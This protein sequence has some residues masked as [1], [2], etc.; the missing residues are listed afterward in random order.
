MAQ[1]TQQYSGPRAGAEPK[2]NPAVRW[3]TILL[4]LVFLALSGVIGRD[5]WYRYQDNDPQNSWV[6][7]VLDWLGTATVNPVGVTVG[8][9]VAL[10]GLWLIITAF[11]PR[12]RR[13]VRIESASSI[14]TRP[15]DI[16]RKA[17]ASARSELGRSNIAS[18]ATR[19]KLTI[20]VED[21]GSQGLDQRLTEVLS[22]EMQ[23]L[24]QAPK[25]RVN[26]HRPTQAKE[27]A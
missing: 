2:G 5:L 10:I 20:D 16:A 26:I 23:R 18:R 9:I 17:T 7:P 1:P 6:R 24:A 27:L 19:K 12:P 4:G 8:V 13:Y 11:K 22:G 21:D 25:V 3:L 14:W 15:V